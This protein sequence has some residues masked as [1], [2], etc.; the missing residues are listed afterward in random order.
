MSGPSITKPVVEF[1]VVCDCAPSEDGTKAYYD[2]EGNRVVLGM[3]LVTG[4]SVADAEAYVYADPRLDCGDGTGPCEF[5]GFVQSPVVDIRFTEEGAA[6]LRKT[7]GQLV[8]EYIAIV[9][10]DVVFVNATLAESLDQR[11]VVNVS[12]VPLAETLAAKLNAAR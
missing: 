11:V 9:I 5:I 7:T 8:G 4:E 10:D 6:R 1:R 3:I 12:S 2:T